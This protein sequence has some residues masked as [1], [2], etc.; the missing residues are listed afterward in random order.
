MP[1]DRGVELAARLSKFRIVVASDIDM[2]KAHSIDLELLAARIVEHFDKADG[3]RI[4]DG[5]TL[6]SIIAGMALDKAPQIIDVERQVSYKPIA[7]EV[8]ATYSLHD[9]KIEKTGGVVDDFVSYFRNRTERLRRIME[10]NRQSLTGILKSIDVIDGLPTGREVVIVGIVNQKI[11]TKNGNIMV[12]LEDETATAKIMFMKNQQGRSADLFARSGSIVNDEVLAVRGKISGPFVI[13]NEFYFP[14]VPVIDQKK[15]SDDI[16]MAFMSDIH[17]GSRYFIE[18]SFARM[19]KWLNGDV[20][21]RKDLAGKIKYMVIAGDV[22]DGVGIYPEQERN[23]SVPDV[24][25]QY[26]LL[27][28]F[29]DSIPDYI[30][31]FIIGGNHDA[32][33][34]AEPQPAF[35]D[36][37]LGDFKRSNIH[38][39]PN[40]S[41]L[42]IDGFNVLAYHGTSL[43]SVIS[44]IPGMSYARP[45][46]A[47]IEILK[48][49]HLSPIYGG[50]VI[51]PAKEDNLI[52]NT[53]PDIL[54]MGHVHKN[55][56]ANY[57]GIDIVNSGTWQSQTDFQI[58]Q[59]H[60]PSPCIMPVLEMKTH[61][62]TNLNFNE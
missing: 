51:V 50:N 41:A 6:D 37:I 62:Y 61:T 31:I 45:E 52:I 56:F 27:F 53:V 32:V 12:V 48:R 26:R 4:L 2:E 38:F 44:A 39:L 17:V 21:H 20:D 24:Y 23:L 54:H 5:K 35:G 36:E 47:M 19:I 29:L 25:L 15:S 9:Y 33:Q 14:D 55:G 40:P 58:R 13:A 59:G 16:A 28:N 18:S 30:H 11:T 46:K 60:I 3:L 1:A 49:R 34:R 42:T 57:H 8:D 10:S 7:A 22:V 43:D